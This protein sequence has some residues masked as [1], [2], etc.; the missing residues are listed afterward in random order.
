MKPLLLTT[1]AIEAGA[2]VALLGVPS[3]FAQLLFA[4][5]LEGAVA[6]TVARVGG[7]GLLTL[8]VAAWFALHDSQSCAARGLAS[9]M[10]LYNLGAALILGAAG[11]RSAPVGIALWPVVLLHAGMAAWCATQLLRTAHPA[12]TS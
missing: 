12:T 1:A 8:A 2:G 10:V 3:R 6:L 7:M 11:L 4:A 9:A 5:P